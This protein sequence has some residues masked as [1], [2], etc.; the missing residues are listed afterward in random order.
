MACIL[1]PLGVD[2]LKVLGFLFLL[3]SQASG[4]LAN[5]ARKHQ[6]EP[7][8]FSPS[9]TSPAEWSS[10]SS[11]QF[12]Y[13]AAQQN[14]TSAFGLSPRSDE[15]QSSVSSQELASP[16]QLKPLSSPTENYMNPPLPGAD[17]PPR[18][19]A[20]NPGY[21]DQTNRNNL[22]FP[23]TPSQVQLQ[24]PQRRY[25]PSEYPYY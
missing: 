14:N 8:I 1:K 9:T 19:Y 4:V 5:L 24:Q 18:I 22:L 12:A 2:C 20:G 21:M 13:Q 6:Q 16:V 25:N 7:N 23:H 17:Y 10:S 11:P 15:R 3:A